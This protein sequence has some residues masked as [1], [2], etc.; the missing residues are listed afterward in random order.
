MRYYKSHRAIAQTN[1]TNKTNKHAAQLTVAK[2]PAATEAP[3]AKKT[4][5][6]KEESTSKDIA[7]MTVAELKA[8]AKEKGITGYTS[9]KKAE[10]IA[11]LS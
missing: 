8:M 9:M 2:P 5:P 6:I 3:K 10:L 11:A 7:S 4:T 1:K